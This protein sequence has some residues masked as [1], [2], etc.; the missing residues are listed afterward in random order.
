MCLKT[1]AS[2]SSSERASSSISLVPSSTESVNRSRRRSASAFNTSPMSG[3]SG[4]IRSSPGM[5]FPRKDVALCS[6]TADEISASLNPSLTAVSAALTVEASS[7]RMLSSTSARRL[8][9]SFLKIAFLD[10]R[11]IV[12]ASTPT[13][14]A[15]SACEHPPVKSS[16]AVSCFG[17]KRYPP[18]YCL[19]V[20]F[21]II[22]FSPK[23]KRGRIAPAPLPSRSLSVVKPFDFLRHIQLVRCHFVLRL[24]PSSFKEHR[25]LR[26]LHRSFVNYR[27]WHFPLS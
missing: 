19:F 18:D 6:R 16:R 27:H 15:A 10:H 11:D 4:S 3:S 12:S 24:S 20:S 17:E 13:R 9:S 2:R 7:E 23:G 8:A 1:Q 5:S 25:L 26:L 14:R 22:P 21:S